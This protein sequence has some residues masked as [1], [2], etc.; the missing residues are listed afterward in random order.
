MSSI[1]KSM[2]RES[3]CM[4]PRICRAPSAGLNAGGGGAA[5]FST[6]SGLAGLEGLEGLGAS[7]RSEISSGL[8][9]P[10]KSRAKKQRKANEMRDKL[11]FSPKFQDNRGGKPVTA[12][13]PAARPAGLPA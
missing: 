10:L 3:R 9:A 12:T 13:H 7:P 6:F 5:G 11:R 2:M 1:R 8:N 4:I